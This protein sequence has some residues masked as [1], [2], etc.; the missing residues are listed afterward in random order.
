ME[1]LNSEILFNIYDINKCSE[2]EGPGRRYVIWFQ[3]CSIGCKG[4]FNKNLQ[5]FKIKNLVP[6]KDI[7]ENIRESLEE[8]GIIGVTLL[9]GE[10]TE[11][12]HLVTLLNEINKLE[13]NILLFTGKSY[14][15][16]DSDIRDRCHYIVDGKFEEEL[17]IKNNLIGSSNQKLYYKGAQIDIDLLKSNNLEVTITSDEVKI[18]G[19][20]NND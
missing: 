18:T 17:V 7:V 9:G 5:S 12:Q 15:V 13:L 4:C 3:G 10:P 19:S 2:V 20:L 14:A 16:L 8:N 11:Q 6:L 1:K